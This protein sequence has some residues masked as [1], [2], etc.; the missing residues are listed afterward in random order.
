MTLVEQVDHL[1]GL[2]EAEGGQGTSLVQLAMLNVLESIA[3]E[4]DRI[5]DLLVPRGDGEE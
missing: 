1:R 2:A 5:I 4:V 3:F